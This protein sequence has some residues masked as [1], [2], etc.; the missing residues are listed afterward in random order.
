MAFC[1][2][3]LKVCFSYIKPA[4]DQ[5]TSSEQAANKWNSCIKAAS[6]FQ[7]KTNNC[8]FTQILYLFIVNARFELFQSY[9]VFLLVNLLTIVI[10]N[11]TDYDFEQSKC[12]IAM[13][14]NYRTL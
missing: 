7:I 13:P 3:S 11:A 5:W 2:C 14:V 4:L 1:S 10:M 9:S 8:V 12:R 6:N